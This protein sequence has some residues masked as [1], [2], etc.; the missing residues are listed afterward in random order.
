MNR[1]EPYIALKQQFLLYQLG[2]LGEAEELALR[3]GVQ[4]YPDLLQAVQEWDEQEEARLMAGVEPPIKKVK[5]RLFS[6]SLP[7]LQ[8]AA[9]SSHH[10][11][12]LRPNTTAADLSRWLEG[13]LEVDS[14]LSEAHS[15]L[16]EKNKE[17]KTLLVHAIGGFPEEVHHHYIE[18]FFILEGTCNI[19]LEDSPTVQLEPGSFFRIPLF[20]KHSVKITSECPCVFIC[21]RVY[22]S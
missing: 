3:T 10:F 13:K 21:Q 20:R 18:Q 2:K 8:A 19:Y 17:A 22:L 1:D 7:A 6:S 15:Q 5:R 14:D 4:A 9:K 12:I 11:P 16:L